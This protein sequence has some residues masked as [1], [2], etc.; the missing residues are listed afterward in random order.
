MA[1][2]KICVLMICLWFCGLSGC[3]LWHNL[4]PHRMRRLNRVPPPHQ[5]PEFTLRESWQH[6]VVVAA[7]W[8]SAAMVVRAQNQEP[9]VTDA[10]L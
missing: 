3:S 1:I 5:D 2:R 7:N 8:D 10:G 6:A 4:Q 9:G